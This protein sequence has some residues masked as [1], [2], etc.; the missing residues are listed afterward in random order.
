M[1]VPADDF[2][3]ETGGRS[4]ALHPSPSRILLVTLALVVGSTLWVAARAPTGDVSLWPWAIAQCVIV[5]LGSWLLHASMRQARRLARL[6]ALRSR[7]LLERLTV[8]TQSAGMCGW[9][10]DFVRRRITWLDLGPGSTQMSEEQMQI[11]GQSLLEQVLPED[12]QQAI[13]QRDAATRCGAPTCSTRCRMRRPDGTLRDVQV[14]MRFFYDMNGR[15]LRVL[16]ANL[17]VT[18]S[19]RRERE[20]EAL[21]IR[22]EVATRAARAGVWEWQEADECLWWN[23]MMYAI[24]GCDPATFKPYIG[25]VISMIHAED[26]PLAQAAW[27]NALHRSGYLNVQ[28]RIQRPDGMIAY[29]THYARVVTDA[30]TR[31]RRMVGIT[32]D[33]GAQVAAEQRERQLQG[34]LRE[35]SRRSGM[36]EVATGVLHNVGNVLNS[37]GVATSTA[38]SRLRASPI[39][40]VTRVAELFEAQ[41]EDLFRFLSSDPRGRQMPAYLRA[42]GAQLARDA[43]ALEQELQTLDGNLR[44][45]REIVRAQQGFARADDAEESVDVRELID[46]AL[47]LQGRDLK[48]VEIVR[49]IDELPLVRTDRHRLLQ[50][51]VNFIANARD[52]VSSTGAGAR[53]ITLR[54]VTCADS[55]LEISVEDTGVGIPA[56]LLGRVWEFGFTTKTN[57]H[58]FGLHSAA[59]TAQAMGGSVSAHSDGPGRG[60]RFGV[61]IPIREDARGARP[62]MQASA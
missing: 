30:A 40:R 33:I 2:S 14:Y 60:A 21:S 1:P 13:A 28:F 15:R 52:A 31:E 51:V 8:A 25:S 6:E 62:A 29:V 47:I 41:Q 34:K 55:Q 11:A 59:L 12:L 9:E 54:A 23:D 39:E 32:L 45:L 17:D 24:Y 7:R 50:I 20:L 10:Y 49:E 22:F 38:Q 36:A 53:R 48:G 57:G 26:L 43:V 18:D 4:E 5:S 35:A 19:Q 3:E 42:L 37:L 58:G 61:R 56:H 44:Y 46:T 16:G 27:E